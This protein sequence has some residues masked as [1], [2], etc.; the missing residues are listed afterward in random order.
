MPPEVVTPLTFHQLMETNVARCRRWHRG[1]PDDELWTLSDWSNALAGE[2]GEACNVVK[3]I[4]RHETGQLGL[5]DPPLEDLQ[6]KL[7]HEIA[8]VI[9]YAFLL[10]HKAGI[11]LDLAVREKFNIVSERQDFPERL[12]MPTPPPAE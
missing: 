5:L 10:A 6:A 3:K 4:R 1:Y 2:A 8:D 7:A 12:P 9:L 11:D